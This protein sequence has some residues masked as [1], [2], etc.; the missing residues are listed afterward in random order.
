MS[1]FTQNIHPTTNGASNDFIQ[2][3]IN[4]DFDQNYKANG[5]T[6]YVQNHLNGAAEFI[7]NHSDGEFDQ[8]FKTNTND[9]PL[10]HTKSSSSEFVQN[11]TTNGLDDRLSVKSPISGD[12]D[13]FFTE[14]S[15]SFY[16]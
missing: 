3:H 6:E 12:D 7:Q 4:G 9:F 1:E 2:N 11:Y 10:N 14:G 16:I 8:N 5:T 15:V 13:A